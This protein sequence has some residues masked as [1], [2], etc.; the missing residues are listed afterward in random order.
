MGI[1][2]VVPSFPP[3][4]LLNEYLKI[5]QPTSLYIWGVSL[6]TLLKSL[7]NGFFGVVIGGA[8]C[9]LTQY[10]TKRKVHTLPPMP[11]AP[12]LSTPSL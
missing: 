4:Q 5:P 9:D 7:I 11:V 2:L 10:L 6:A 1:T 3:A 8:V 12:H